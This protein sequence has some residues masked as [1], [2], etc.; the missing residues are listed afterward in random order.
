M[1]Q[2]WRNFYNSSKEQPLISINKVGDKVCFFYQSGTRMQDI[3]FL[4]QLGFKTSAHTM[5]LHSHAKMNDTEDRTDGIYCRTARK[6][7]QHFP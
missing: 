1:E 2:P 3:I 4:I 6:I 5:Q 7:W